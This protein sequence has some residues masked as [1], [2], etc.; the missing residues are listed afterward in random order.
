MKYNFLL[1]MF[2]LILYGCGKE[3]TQDP[4]KITPD[5]TPPTPHKNDGKK[6]VTLMLWG[7]FWCANCKRELPEVQTQLKIRLGDDFENVKL[8]LWVPTGALPNEKPTIEVANQYRDKLKMEAEAFID[9]W[10]W[11]TFRSY[12]KGVKTGMPAGVLLNEN[13]EVLKIFIPG[14]TT[15]V[16]E[17]IVNSVAE[18]LK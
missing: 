12:L 1:I 9:P 4:H 2:V 5:P 14:M 18:G 16:P 7:A 10:R 8:Q 11:K 17:E 6:S 3:A 13:G 15:F